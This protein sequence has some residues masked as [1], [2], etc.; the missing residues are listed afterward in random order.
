MRKCSRCGV[1]KPLA[2]YYP[3]RRKY[4]QDGWNSIC[5]S[6]AK[7]KASEWAKKN[8][9]RRRATAKNWWLN[10]KQ[11]HAQSVKKWTNKNRHRVNAKLVERRRL[12]GVAKPAWANDFFI[13]EIYDLARIRTAV[14]GFAWHVDHIVPLKHPLVCGLHCEANLRVIPAFENRSKGNHYWP[15]MPADLTIPQ[16]SVYPQ[17]RFK[18]TTA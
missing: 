6:C 11:L 15:D 8:K 14:T 7:E 2:E 17:P 1:E 4:A 18:A 12:N 13:D 5:I 10:N 3:K 16:E 9:K